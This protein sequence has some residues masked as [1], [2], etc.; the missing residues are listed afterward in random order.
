MKRIKKTAHR[1]AELFQTSV[2]DV[3]VFPLEDD[4]DDIVL[5]AKKAI[6]PNPTLFVKSEKL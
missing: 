1:E 5:T 6:K 3:S 4:S 2:Q